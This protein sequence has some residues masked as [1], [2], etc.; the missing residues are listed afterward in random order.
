MTFLELI[1][2]AECYRLEAENQAQLQEEHRLEAERQE[3]L[4]EETMALA[5]KAVPSGWEL[6]K[7]EEEKDE[8][9]VLNMA[10]GMDHPRNWKRGD[11]IRALHTSSRRDFIKG[12]LYTFGEYIPTQG[13]VKVLDDGIRY[14]Y[15]WNVHN[16]EWV[17]RPEVKRPPSF[18]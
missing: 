1:N 8:P 10:I 14:V 5:V 13:L 12:E 15:K 7:V 4:W 17:S 9:I 3:K 6:R 16:F 11:V 18:K 2:K